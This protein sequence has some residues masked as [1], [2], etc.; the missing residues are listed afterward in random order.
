M[1]GRN[2]KYEHVDVSL[3]RKEE[4]AGV[5]GQQARLNTQWKQPF[6]GLLVCFFCG[7]RNIFPTQSNRFIRLHTGAQK[8]VFVFC[9]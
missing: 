6:Y 2:A 4:V 7:S 3:E 5:G 8:S 1:C 9:L